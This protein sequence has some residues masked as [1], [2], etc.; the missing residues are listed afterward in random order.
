MRFT[1]T[2]ANVL[3]Y[4]VEQRLIAPVINRSRDVLSGAVQP[5]LGKNFNLLVQLENPP[6]ADSG[7]EVRQHLFVKQEGRSRSGRVAGDLGREWQLYQ[8][9]KSTAALQPLQRWLP[10]ALHFD[11]DRAILILNYLWDYQELESFYTNFP[12]TEP[13]PVTVAAAIGQAVATL[14]RAT[15]QDPTFSAWL[16]EVEGREP[17]SNPAREFYQEMA[18]LTPEIY[19]RVPIEGMQFYRLY[20]R[21]PQLAAAIAELGKTNRPCCLTHGDLKFNNIL[22]P[23]SYGPDLSDSSDSANLADLADLA[24][25]PRS[26]RLIDW[27]KWAWGDPSFDLGSL[28]AG[29]L[30][31]WLRSLPLSRDIPVE[32]ALQ[33]A[34]LPLDRLQPSLQALLQAYQQAFPELGQHPEFI[35]RTIQQA[36]LVLCKSVQTRLFYREPFDN[37]SIALLQVG[38]T[39]LCQ[40]Q[41]SLTTLWGQVADREVR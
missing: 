5:R 3:D 31:L 8:Q 37:T 32:T 25:A 26:I 27:E 34:G 36:G 39:L 41:T 19:K 23:V 9:I 7:S 29:Y 11:A 6:H 2:S 17:A 1:L 14:H 30:K 24:D 21:D 13:L 22:L 33:F 28:V 40:P 20:Q 35:W 10:E 38:R 4:L 15:W 12:T 18:E 16:D